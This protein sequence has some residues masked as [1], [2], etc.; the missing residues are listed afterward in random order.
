MSFLNWNEH[1]DGIELAEAG[2]LFWGAVIV[3]IIVVAIFC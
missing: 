2:A 3:V 1:H